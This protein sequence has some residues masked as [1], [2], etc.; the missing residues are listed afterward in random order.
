MQRIDSWATPWPP[1]SLAILASISRR[2]GDATLVD[3]AVETA[4]ERGTPAELASTLEPD[5]IVIN[6]GFPSIEDDAA[7]ASAVKA[8][9]PSSLV[10]GFGVFFTLLG[11]GAMNAF[12]VFDAGIAGEPEETFETLFRTLEKGADPVGIPGIMLRRESDIITGPP[13]PFIRDLDALPFPAR[14]LL[15]NDRY[16]LPHNG[17]PFTLVNSARGCPQRCTFC[18]TPAYYGRRMRRHSIDYILA[19]MNECVNSFGLDHFLF[20]EET[21]TRNRET[22]LKFC[23]ALGRLDAPVSWAATTRAD[24]MDDELASAMKEAGCF[25]LGLGVESADRRILGEAGKDQDVSAIPRA[26]ASCRKAGILTMGHFIFGLPGETPETIEKTIDFALALELDYL[27]CYPAVPYPGTPL[28]DEAAEKGWATTR[29]WRDYDFGGASV[30]DIGTVTPAEVDAARAR[31]FRKFY[32][33]PRYVAR[34]V[35]A[36]GA[37]PARL[38]GAGRFLTWMKQQRRS[39][40]P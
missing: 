39:G 6:T 29:R 27:Q 32:L 8:A 19:E 37:N 13:P 10:A 26:V 3:Y 12:P 18:I 11:E 9:S 34:Q 40:G 1:L 5:I 33:R 31:L 15:P 2:Y 21:F 7:A 14:D 25:M 38:R 17:K 24:R 36:L 28:G 23:E 20:W 16:I 4:E 22:T 30:L 35:A